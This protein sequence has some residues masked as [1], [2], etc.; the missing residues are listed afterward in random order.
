[1]LE[2]TQ[3]NLLPALDRCNVILNSLQG[4][5]QYHEHSPAFDVPASAFSLILDIIRCIRLL[6]HHI[7]LFAS[8]EHRRFL[9]FS[10]WLR[11]AIDFQAADPTSATGLELIEQDP[12]LDFALVLTYIR[13]GLEHSKVDELLSSPAEAPEI[14]ANPDMYSD[15][16]KGLDAFKN[17]KPWK[18]D[19]LKLSSYYDEWCR[20]NQILVDHITSWQRVNTL[21]PGGLVLV[22]SDI[23]HCDLR[24]VFEV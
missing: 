18:E 3:E 14:H 24:M 19:I 11:Y 2:I 23:S 5:A 20:R 12:G 4:L 21:M 10:K 13:E 17:S 9:A 22:D 16:T 1:V 8:E 6:G 7:L 15:L